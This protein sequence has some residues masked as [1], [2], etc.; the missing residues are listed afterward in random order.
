MAASGEI[1]RV[2]HYYPRAFVGDGGVTAAMWS[3]AT[4]TAKQGVDV[5]VIYDGGDSNRRSGVE[6]IHVCHRGSGATRRP[7]N[8]AGA[9]REGDLVVLHSGWTPHNQWAG[10]QASRAGVPFV[11]M[12]HGAYQAQ[13][14]RR[15][16]AAKRLARP[17][18]RA[19]L[20]G[21]AAVHVF[22]PSETTLVHNM[23]PH[24]KVVVAAT[25][26]ELSDEVAQGGGGYI[27]WLGR[28][29][30]EHK[31]LDLLIDAVALMDPADRPT[32][33]LR[34]RDSSNSRDQVQHLVVQ[35]NLENYIEVG[36]PISG[37]AK[38]EFVRS[39]DGYVHPS[40][41][42]CHSIALLEFLGMG[43]PSL[44]SSG[45]HISST[46]REANAAIVADPS[47]ESLAEGLL[48]LSRY[49]DTTTLGH[50]ARQLVASK[51]NWPQAVSEF[52]GQARSL[53]AT[54]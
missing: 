27:A 51:F 49:A 33:R 6:P 40:R 20:H 25:G 13:I 17:F 2:V 54:G 23:A 44:V 16:A 21:A 35:R 22:F 53:A 1:K 45:A 47:S 42:E 26:F 14:L 43:M 31:G 9:L 8:L 18:E 34:G 38:H 7:V 48:E 5:A 29:D 3:W 11:V 41:W 30:I 28:Y 36:G 24:A 37:D 15:R 19:L 4:A 10:H 52:L 32:I 12:P 50:N 46:L 39:A